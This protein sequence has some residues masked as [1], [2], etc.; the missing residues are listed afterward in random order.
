MVRRTL[1]RDEE[2]KLMVRCAQLYYDQAHEISQA[3]VASQL[4]INA[5]K[6][7]RLLRQAQIEGIVK[8]AIDPPRLQR[9]ELQLMDAFG[10]KDVV[11]V[12]S[13]E[14]R[15][16]EA[17]GQAAAEYFVRAAQD[18][19]SIGLAPGYSV[20]RMIEHLHLLPFSGHKLYPLAAESTSILR[21]F[22][23]TQLAALMMTKYKDDSQVSAFTYRIPNKP[24]NDDDLPKYRSFLKSI[25]QDEAFSRLLEKARAADVLLMGVGAVSRPDHSLK[26][27]FEAY[28]LS[29]KELLAQG[30]VGVINYHFYDREGRTLTSSDCPAL[31]DI[32][33][34]MVRIDLDSFRRAVKAFGRSLI[35]LAGGTYKIEA[36]RAALKGRFFNILITDVNLAEGLLKPEAART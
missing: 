10:L 9:L 18:D 25:A 17:V 4:G 23:P 21:H 30:A 1:A 29:P 6:V 34:S 36:V 3:E 12:P 22:Y 11:V 2:V 27:F 20:Q 35:A 31:K 14:G 24:H 16:H 28:N 7:S 15:T 33:S 13:D 19:I 26:A 5:T 8:V 32:E